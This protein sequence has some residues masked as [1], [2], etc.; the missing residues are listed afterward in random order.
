[1]ERLRNGPT[2]ARMAWVMARAT[3]K[4]AKKPTEPRNIRSRRGSVAISSRYI[5]PGEK[6]PW[7]GRAEACAAMP[8]SLPDARGRLQEAGAGGPGGV[9]A[10]RGA[11]HHQ[12]RSQG[13]RG[14]VLVRLLDA[15]QDHARRGAAHLHGALV[16]RG[17]REGAPGRHRG[18]VVAD[19]A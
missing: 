17:E 8:L 15:A 10:R 18:V 1:M 13:Q 6:L 16:D 11:A 7:S 9:R 5:R 4:P 3:P 19:H 12:A 2:S 14:D